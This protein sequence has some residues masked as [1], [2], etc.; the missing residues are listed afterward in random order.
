MALLQHLTGICSVICQADQLSCNTQQQVP[1]I[2][3]EPHAASSPKQGLTKQH[4]PTIRVMSR[5]PSSSHTER[6]LKISCLPVHKRWLMRGPCVFAD[7]VTTLIHKYQ[8]AIFPSI[9]K[10]PTSQSQQLIVK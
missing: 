2:R 1:W 3:S 5:S 9:S 6:N 10:K 8:P 7:A 4:N